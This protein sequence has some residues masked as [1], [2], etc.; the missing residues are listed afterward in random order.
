M[1]ETVGISARRLT[2]QSMPSAPQCNQESI[3]GKELQRRSYVEILAEQQ[4]SNLDILSK[5]VKDLEKSLEP[6]LC[7][8]KTEPTGVMPNDTSLGSALELMHSNIHQTQDI[9]K[10]V[11]SLIQRLRPQ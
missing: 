10:L 7:V 4:Q 3:S 2:G 9:T 6:M 8:P 1:N 5:T 11:D